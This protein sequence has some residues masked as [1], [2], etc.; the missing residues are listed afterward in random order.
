MVDRSNLEIVYKMLALVKLSKSQLKAT[1]PPDLIRANFPGINT[2]QRYIYI[3]LIH[4][5]N[6]GLIAII[7]G[8]A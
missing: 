7:K 4:K 3:V 5:M 2:L 1:P 8:G 6:T